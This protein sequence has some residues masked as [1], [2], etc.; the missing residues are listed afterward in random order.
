M[1]CVHF[2]DQKRNVGIH[3][4][5][6][7]I[8]DD[9]IAGAREFFFGWAGDARI[10]RGENEIAVEC[11][12]ESF[13]RRDFALACGIGVSRC[14]RAA[15]AYVFRRAF[16]S[17]DRGEFKPRMICE[18]FYEALT[19]E[20]GRAENAGAP[21]EDPRGVFSVS[22]CTYSMAL[23]REIALVF[24]EISWRLKYFCL[25]LTAHAAPSW[26]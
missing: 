8:A 17:C 18:Q 24:R 10:E 7:R 21:F 13:A 1:R 20:T 5:I 14:Q 9:G 2:G 6:L 15:S 22:I 23:W 19:D 3:A 4:V 12:L 16:R 11:W 25:P 26:D